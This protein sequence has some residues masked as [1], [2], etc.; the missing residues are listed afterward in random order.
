[1]SMH[2]YIKDSDVML[3]LYV[4]ISHASWTMACFQKS[5]TVHS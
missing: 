5:I 2:V 3:W 4:T 1:M